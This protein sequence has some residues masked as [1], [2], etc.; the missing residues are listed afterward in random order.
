M[1]LLGEE[2]VEEWLNRQG[3]FTIRGIKLGVHEMDILA[4]RPRADG[5]HECRHIEVQISTNPIAYVSKVPRKIQM[6][7]GIGPDNA[8]TRP[9]DELMLGIREW[10]QKK[11]DHP[12]KQILRQRL[13]VGHWTRELVVNAVKHPE[14]LEIFQQLGV[15]VIRLESIVREMIT[16]QTTISSAAGND[17]VTLMHLG[18]KGGIPP[19]HAPPGL[20]EAV[21]DEAEEESNDE[22]N[23]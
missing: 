13:W 3:Y 18:A 5:Q 16:M 19:A 17:L 21:Q 4:F 15:S 1:A 2:V 6:E 11:F 22:P 23:H 14:E 10:I 20:L 12:K 8:K 7:R 9:S